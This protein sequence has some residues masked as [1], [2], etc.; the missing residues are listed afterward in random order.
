MRLIQFSALAAFMLSACMQPAPKSAS[1]ATPA[2]PAPS[3][4]SEVLAQTRASDWREPAPENLL[5]LELASGRVVMEL[6]PTFAPHHADNIRAL[7]HEH[8]Y[9]GLAILRVQENYVVQW[10]DPDEKRE[11]KNAQRTI[12]GEFF[13]SMS[14]LNFTP[15]PDGDVYAPEVGYSDGFAAAR[16]PKSGQAWL[17][18]CYGA[19]GVGRGMGPDSG[20]GPE[21]YVVIGHSP[22][23][24][25]RNI[26]VAGRVLQGMENLSVLPR[27]TGALGFYEKPEQ[28]VTIR[29]LSVASDIP[30]AERP[31]L[32]VLR[33]DTASWNAYVDV[34]RNRRDPWFL[35]PTGHVELCNVGVPVRAIP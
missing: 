18:H 1:A 21:L 29:S 6:A 35:D 4:P 34:R 25:D 19:L 3:T 8:Y 23:H 12:P 26:T 32:Q 30:A 13:R 15:L 24:L 2:T 14:G 9:D 20:G 31:H 22:R 33:T 10:G 7:A 16:D 11:I 17:A 5:V 28:Y 27:G